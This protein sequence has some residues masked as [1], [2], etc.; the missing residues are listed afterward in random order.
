[1]Q[2][3]FKMSKNNTSL[4]FTWSDASI[5]FNSPK[6]MGI[7]NITPDSFYD[8]GKTLSATKSIEQALQM[9]EQGAHIIDIGGQSSRPGAEAITAHQELDRIALTIEGILQYNPEIIISVDTY[10]SHV[11]KETV[12][13]GAKII[14]DISAGNMDTEMLATIGKL[15]IPYIAMHMQGTPANMQ[16]APNYEDVSQEIV[17]YFRQKLYLFEQHQIRQVAIDPGFGFGKTIE[18]NYEI[19]QQLAIFKQLQRP[20]LVG[21]SRKSM[22]YKPLQTDA[23]GALNGTTA[24]HMA[25]LIQGAN[26]LRVHD[27]L[28]AK[29]VIALYGMMRA[30]EE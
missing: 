25:A 19:L 13:L 18:Q 9:V 22:V 11:A 20:L 21:L 7:V 30:S 4:G 12:A 8:G 29:E 23:H 5:D 28:E 3:F 14:N 24:L 10:H 2:L 1:M 26:I 15:Q 27:V 16:K 6:I 17:E